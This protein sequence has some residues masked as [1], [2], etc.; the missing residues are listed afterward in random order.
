M[1]FNE[2][3]TESIQ[4]EREVTDKFLLNRQKANNR[5]FQGQDAPQRDSLVH[6]SI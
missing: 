6:K 1:D 5:L 4:S 3:F 2:N